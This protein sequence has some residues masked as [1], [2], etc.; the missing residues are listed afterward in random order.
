MSRRLG[1]LD[2]H[3]IGLALGPDPARCAN[4]V[5]FENQ[6]TI[7]LSETLGKCGRSGSR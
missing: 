5:V 4:L 6:F 1:S 3:Q 7:R 2:A